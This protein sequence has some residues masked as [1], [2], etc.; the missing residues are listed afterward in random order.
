M[1]H[2]ESHSKRGFFQIELYFHNGSS[3]TCK[4]STIC[5]RTGWRGML[6]GMAGD[7]PEI[8]SISG[9]AEHSL[10]HTSHV[11]NE[12]TAEKHGRHSMLCISQPHVIEGRKT[13]VGKHINNLTHRP[14]IPLWSIEWIVH[15]HHP[16]CF[17]T[18]PSLPC[19]YESHSSSPPPISPHPRNDPHCCPSEQMDMLSQSKNCHQKRIGMDNEGAILM[20]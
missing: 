1:T 4:L 3:S 11:E 12:W 16:S 9:H 2:H 14:G 18:L 15:S 5:H 6:S 10:H 20:M 19:I 8:T 17:C 13:L 7:T